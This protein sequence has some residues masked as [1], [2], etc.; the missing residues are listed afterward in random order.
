M[1]F[2]APQNAV[3][4]SNG[5]AVGVAPSNGAILIYD[6][7][8]GVKKLRVSLDG[9][10]YVDV[11]TGSSVSGTGTVNYL[12]YWTGATTISAN[13]AFQIDAVN[14][15]LGIGL[16]PAHKLDV[17]S[18]TSTTG[19]KGIQNQVA[20]DSAQALGTLAG[21]YSI[22]YVTAGAD[23]VPVVVG[24][25]FHISV[26]ASVTIP[27]EYGGS[28]TASASGAAVISTELIGVSASAGFSSSG[29]CAA[30]YGS[31]SSANISSGTVTAAYG[32]YIYTNR[33]AG[34]VTSMYGLYVDN[35]NTGTTNYAIY[36][37]AGRV[38]FGGEVQAAFGIAMAIVAKAANYTATADEYAITVDAS[39]AARTITIPNAATLV[40][41]KVFVI[42]KIDSSAN[43][44]TIAI[45]TG[46]VDGV[47]SISFNTQYQSYTIISDGTN[48][49][50]I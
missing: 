47:A 44:V 19:V 12:A 17:S 5:A 11:A 32:H 14:G 31:Y 3:A 45:A 15:R 28:F 4:L 33:S 26:S 49:H 23:A 38:R 34:I 9:A 48:W 13:V 29:T 2:V 22:T 37:N 39:G 40:V 43:N 10:A 21:L 6:N 36:T 20:H 1:S 25:S 42:K 30:L 27:S 7:T 16:A 18:N 35:V 50:V 8:G 41:G 46:T 24:G